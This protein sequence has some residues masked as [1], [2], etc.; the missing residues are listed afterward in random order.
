MARVVEF[1]TDNDVDT[2]IA[3][4]LYARELELVAYDHEIAVAQD[5]L[6]TADARWLD[7]LALFANGKSSPF[8]NRQQLLSQIEVVTAQRKLSELRYAS[9][10]KQLPIGTRRTDAIDRVRTKN[11]SLAA[12]IDKQIETL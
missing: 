4:A 5:I 8:T 2:Q 1:I 6:D 12:S 7:S 11:A 10:N 3:Q 9:Q